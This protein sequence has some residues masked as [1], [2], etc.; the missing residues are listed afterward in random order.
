[1]TGINNVLSTYIPTSDISRFN[2]EGI[3]Q[4]PVDDDSRMQSQAGEYF[5]A[6]VYTSNHVYSRSQGAFDPTVGPLVNLWGF[7]WEGRQLNAPDSA[8]VDSVRSLVGWQFIEVEHVDDTMQI[9]RIK[10]G[11]TMDFSALAKGYGVDL[12]CHGLERFGIFDYYVEIGGEVRVGGQSPSGGKWTLGINTPRS[13]AAPTSIFAKLRVQT[14]SLATSGNYRNFYIVDGRK[15]WHTINPKTGYPEANNLLSASVIHDHCITA[16][17]LATACMV[18]GLDN[19]MKMMEAYED[20]EAYFIYE[21]G[22]G[23]LQEMFTT[24]FSQYLATL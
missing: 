14:K 8:T 10:E 20:A 9:M 22:N 11:V 21:D 17:A 13:D 19:A 16:D 2:N 4:Y 5:M 6:N 7:G 1:M 23:E 15:V 18:M 12:L 3:V 24:G